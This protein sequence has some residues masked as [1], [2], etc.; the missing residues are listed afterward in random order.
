MDSNKPDNKHFIETDDGSHTLYSDKFKATYHS[1]HGAI[2][3]S[4]HIFIKNGFVY[5]KQ[6]QNSAQVNILEIGLGT[7][8]NAFLTYLKAKETITKINYH[9]IEAFPVMYDD[10]IKLNYAS[11]LAQTEK[12]LFVKLHELKWEHTIQLSPDFELTKHHTT[13]QQFETAIKFDIIYYDAFSPKE[14]P[15]LW[16]DEIFKKMY[17]FLKP[18]GILITYCAQGQMK[19][20]L[21][22]AGF[23]V[24]SLPGP[25][26]KREITRAT[27]PATYMF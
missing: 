10:A 5:Q 25:K 9:G 13:I 2:N 4:S 11:Q 17:E 26:G 22:F 23:V 7:G 18:N 6:V 15:E 12:F 19:R 14:Q 8:L 3:E 1:T 21:K 20:N 24:E 27:R 16:T